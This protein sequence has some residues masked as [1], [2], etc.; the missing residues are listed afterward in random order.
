MEAGMQ[1]AVLDYKVAASLGTA[2]LGPRLGYQYHIQL[3]P[4]NQ[5]PEINQTSPR[6][7][8]DSREKKILDK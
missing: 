4:S 5:L 7:I 1:L 3:V 6:I 2:L 8:T